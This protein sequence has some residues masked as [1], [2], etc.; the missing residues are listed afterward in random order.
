MSLAGKIALI[1]GGASGL[2]FGTALR[3]ASK[4]CKVVI[5]DISIA[6]VSKAVGTIGESRAMTGVMD[7]TDEAQV[8]E[9]INNIKSR[10]GKLDYVINCAG[11]APPM[12]TLSKKG[13]HSLSQFANV[14]KV[15]TIGTFNVVRLGAELMSANEPDGS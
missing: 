9:V 14:I 2:G 5:A 4:E 11:I 7:V 8:S 6:N 3:L 15:N 13:P 1:T 10:W 12:K